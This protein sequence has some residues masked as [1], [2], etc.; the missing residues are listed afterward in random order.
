MNFPIIQDQKVARKSDVSGRLSLKWWI[1]LGIIRGYKK[2][3]IQ[4]NA[5]LHDSDNDYISLFIF[6]RKY[7]CLYDF[8]RMSIVHFRD[9]Q[10]LWTHYKVYCH[11]KCLNMSRV[12]ELLMFAND[13]IL[14]HCQ[15]C[16]YCFCWLRRIV[17]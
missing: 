2:H 12:Y 16:E 7:N 1:F 10:S 11:R 5:I 3:C 14:F 17:P 4:M 9:N 8:S 13:C 6:Y 15:Y